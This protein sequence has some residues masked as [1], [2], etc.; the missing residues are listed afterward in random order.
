MLISREEKK[1]EAAKRMKAL[2]IFNPVIKD[3][4]DNNMVEVSEPPLGALYYVDEKQQ[5]IINQIEGQYNCLVY[6]TVRCYTEIGT[7]DS[8][9]VVSDY[10]EEWPDDWESLEDGIVFTYTHNYDAPWC[11]EFGS[12]AI[13]KRNG[14]LVRVG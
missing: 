10:K 3:F 14:G 13:L 5:E 8:F 9:L 7:M 6:L 2:E 11:S 4:E 1:I 12:I